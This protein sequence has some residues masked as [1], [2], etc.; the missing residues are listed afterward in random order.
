MYKRPH[1]PFE[2]VECKL[3]RDFLWR[4]IAE[5]FY[6]VMEETLG[7]IG[8]AELV[9][10]LKELKREMNCISYTEYVAGDHHGNPTGWSNT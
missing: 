3:F 4:K 10:T 6:L 8:E 2:V 7:C 1:N 5:A 9:E